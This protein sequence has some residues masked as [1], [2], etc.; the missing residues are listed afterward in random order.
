[1]KVAFVS[2]ATR[3]IGRAIADRLHERGYQVLYSGTR[4]ERPADL[5]EDRDYI[6]CN[7]ADAEQKIADINYLSHLV[8][9]VLQCF[10]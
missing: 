3:G 10:F 5:P 7:I 9:I 2:G 1:M 6:A 8:Y 4:P